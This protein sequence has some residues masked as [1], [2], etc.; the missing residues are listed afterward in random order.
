MNIGYFFQITDIIM[1]DSSVLHLNSVFGQN[2][3]WQLADGVPCHHPY[4]HC[5]HQHQLS[6]FPRGFVWSSRSL[7]IKIHEQCTLWAGKVGGNTW[8]PKQRPL[9]LIINICLGKKLKHFTIFQ[10]II[11]NFFPI[12]TGNQLKDL[13][14]PKKIDLCPAIS[15]IIFLDTL[16]SLLALNMQILFS[17]YPRIIQTYIILART[18]IC[19]LN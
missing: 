18:Y 1:Y 19:C 13:H 8:C 3:H 7:P 4:H 6:N 16:Y 17:S 5:T 11:I 9:Y 15:L 10:K 2:Q 14:M 12:L